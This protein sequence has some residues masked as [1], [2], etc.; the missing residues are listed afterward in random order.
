MQ[1]LQIIES[2]EEAEIIIS[3]NEAVLFYFSTNS[4]VVGEALLPKVSTLIQEK[5][6]EIKVFNIDLN[7][8]P[9]LAAH[10]NAFI[11]PTILVFFDRKEFIRKI[12]NIGIF[13]LEQA[14]ERP[15]KLIF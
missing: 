13:E 12:R 9:K 11:E 8:S 7:F 5:F 10:F 4:C 1:Q 6:P 2:I 15:Y 3:K 14:I